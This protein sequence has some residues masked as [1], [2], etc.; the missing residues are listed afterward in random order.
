M[1]TPHIAA[2]RGEIAERVLLP[3]DPLRAKHIAETFLTDA[4]C[5]TN[6]RN[7]LG[8]TG[9]YKGQRISV[10]STGM[11]MPAIAIYTK[12]L[13]TEYG[14]KTLIRVGSCGALREDLHLRDIVI[15][16]GSSTDSSIIQNTFGGCLNFAPLA[17]F[18][19]LRKAYAK[20]TELGRQLRVGNVMSNDRFYND[21]L[22]KKKLRDYGILAVEMESAG[23]YLLAAKYQVKA[24]AIF[25]VGSSH[26][27]GEQV[28][29]EERQNSFNDMIKI[30]LDTAIES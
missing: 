1:S 28:T 10:Q 11:G 22:D 5:Y 19:L 27:S 9:F 8:Y 15:A 18:D 16:Q 21:E 26:V 4:K 24:L 25:T 3:G 20:G 7:V 13:I 23:L 30:A 14:A 12:E 29:P 6:I 17:D 2:E